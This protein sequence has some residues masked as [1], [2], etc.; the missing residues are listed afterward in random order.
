MTKYKYYGIVLLYQGE[1]RGFADIKSFGKQ[2]LFCLLLL[3]F[4]ML[5]ML[6]FC[7]C[8][9]C[10]IYKLSGLLCP[11]CGLTRAW[12][13]FLCGNWQQ[14]MQYHLFFLPTPLFIFLYVHRNAAFMPKSKLI[15]AMLLGF[16][17]TLLVYN[18]LR[19]GFA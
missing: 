1:K 8:F 11:G 6:A 18:L 16:A 3:H 4:I 15:D 5:I 17:F 7:C 10:P 14:A 9:G 2:K 13:C 12:L 19:K